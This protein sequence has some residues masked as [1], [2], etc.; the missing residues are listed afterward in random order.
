[1]SSQDGCYTQ[2][3][4]LVPM[5]RA[6]FYR[7]FQPNDPLQSRLFQNRR[8]LFRLTDQPRAPAERESTDIYTAGAAALTG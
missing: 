8:A 5:F 6:L 4:A 3:L 1:M 7:L 2:S